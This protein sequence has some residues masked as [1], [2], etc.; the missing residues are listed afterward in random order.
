MI[1]G[2]ATGGSTGQRDQGRYH[3]GHHQSRKEAH[4][5]VEGQLHQ[6]I[7]V[8]HKTPHQS[9]GPGRFR[10][11]T[12]RWRS[13]S[14]LVVVEDVKGSG[15]G[16]EPDEPAHVG[17]QRAQF[18]QVQPGRRAGVRTGSEPGQ[19]PDRTGSYQGV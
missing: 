17:G 9:D 16:H 6:L 14:L 10:V 11:R 4:G 12:G 8:R 19:N 1:L 7:P 3:G 15:G 2:G 18:T 5:Q 13:H